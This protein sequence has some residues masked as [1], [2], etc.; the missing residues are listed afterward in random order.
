MKT[1][2]VN[3]TVLFWRWLDG[4]TIAYVTGSAVF[5]WSVEERITDIDTC[6][7]LLLVFFSFM[8][9]GKQKGDATPEKKFEIEAEQRQVQIINYDSSKDGN[10]LFL[11][12]I[13]KNAETQKIEGVLQLYSV[14]HKRY[15]PKMNAHGGCFAEVTLSGRDSPSTLFCFTRSDGENKK[16]KKQ[17]KKILMKYTFCNVFVD[18]GWAECNEINSNDFIVSIASSAKYR[19]LYAFT[20]A[21]FILLFDISTG[22]C[23]FNKQ[24]SKVKRVVCYLF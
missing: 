3:D 10:W 5:H 17:Q 20:Q 13:T 16:L 6:L 23:L 18:G 19:C 22:K 14:Q 7:L 11:Q 1:T 24:V 21:G 9:L 12:G 2:E 8:R 15:Q 4:R